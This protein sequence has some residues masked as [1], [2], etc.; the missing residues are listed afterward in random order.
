MT[1]L[2][3]CGNARPPA[4]V[5]VLLYYGLPFAKYIS[6]HVHQALTLFSYLVDMEDSSKGSAKE[7]YLAHIDKIMQCLQICFP[8]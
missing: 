1:C 8:M 4:F 7:A 5:K 3:D 6:I 2:S